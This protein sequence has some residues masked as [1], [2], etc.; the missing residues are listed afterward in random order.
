MS[1]WQINW[2]QNKKRNE[3]LERELRSDLEL[4]EEEQRKAGISKKEAHYAALRAFGNLTL[5]REQT[6][7]IWWWNWLESLARDLRFSL[8]TLRRTPGFSVIAILVM[9]LG[10]G[11]NVALFTVV[12]GVLLKPLPFQ[13]PDRL[14]MLYEAGLLGDDT[15]SSNVVSGGMYAEWKNQNRSYSSLALA[16]GI[17]VGLS[18]SGGQLPEKLN[19]ALF[20]WDMLRT[21][22]VQPALGRDFTLA[23]DSPGANGTVLL[24]WGLWKRRF[25]ADPGI[26]NQTIFLDSQP[27]TVIGVMPKWFDFPDSSTQLWTP[28]YHDKPE[29]EMTSFSNHMFR[30]IGRLKPGVSASQGVADLSVI[31]QR[32]HNEHLNDP[33]VFPSA[34]GRPLLEHIVGEIKKPLYLLLEAT[35][36]LLLIACLNVANLL[37]AR[38]AARRKELAIRT[39]LGGSWLRLIG[40]RLMECLLLSASGGALGLL[41]AFAALHWLTQTRYDMSRVESIHFDGVVAAFTVG[42]VAICALFSGLIAAFSTSDERILSALHEA[43][44]SVGGGRARAMLRKVLLTLEVGLTV[45]LLIGAGLLLKSYE[46]LRSADMGCLTQDVI[47]MHLGI[48]DAR[49]ATPAQRANFYDTLLDRVRALPGADAA[50]FAT[51]APGQ[52]YQTDW[53]F[54]IVEHPPLPQGTGL[55]AL[56][57]WADPKYFNA[58][59]I[60]LLRGRTFDSGKRLDAANEVIISLSF[61]GQYFPGEDALGRHIRVHGKDF[62]IVGIVGDTRYAIGEAPR[63]V[64][65]YPLDAGVEN[66]GTLVIR[67]SH[68]LQQFALP[69]QRIVSEMDH[70]LSVSDVLTMNQLLGKSTL[71]QSFN[72]ALLVAF[73]TLSLVLAAVGLFGVMSY[74]AAQRTTEIGIRVALGAKREQVMR[75]MLL[76]GMRP[77]ILGLVVGLAASL[78]AGQVMRDLLYEIKPIDPSVY[79]AVAATL[80]AVAAFACIVPAWR[81]SRLDPMQALRSE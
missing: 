16:K 30:V 76:D 75:K 36:C 11:A 57:R 31:S 6:L 42:V 48:P 49:Y 9:A 81:A 21:L 22:G 5:I 70:D 1:W 51:V 56:S 33:F 65:Y 60:P 8:R 24:S 80:L 4:E 15:T 18:G 59:G 64:Q 7:A 43:S 38:A 54:S 17:R 37:V 45:I 52:G 72:A 27:Y 66:V 71:D 39:A 40:E 35:C 67:S 14:A 10:I 74:I 12:R 62:V 79:A 44:H 78:E 58:M 28:V 19:S 41:L 68:N 13:D 77:A 46:R 69:V 20:S 73:A 61:A 55:F 3:D 32:I 29:D 47:T 34:S 63:P 23:D 53:S 2:W 26:L 25:G 50:G